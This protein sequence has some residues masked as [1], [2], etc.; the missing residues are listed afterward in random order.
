[1]DY[2]GAMVKTAPADPLFDQGQAIYVAQCSGCHKV[3]G[4]GASG[5]NLHQ[6]L[7][8]FPDRADHLAWI[9][10]GSPAAGTP[11]GD[12]AAGRVS[13]SGGFAAMPGFKDT[14]SPEQIAA[15]AYY[16]RVEFGGEAPAAGAEGA[17]GSAGGSDAGH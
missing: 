14:L 8:T 9:E 16:E 3:D 12:P 17:E 11:Y 2:A 4:T 6:V 7:E 13:Q 15:V 1:L 5:R 10:N